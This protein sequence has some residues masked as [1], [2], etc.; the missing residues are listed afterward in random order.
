[1][2]VFP[3][4]T[5]NTE[6]IGEE[7][8]DAIIDNL[9][10]PRMLAFREVRVYDE[11]STPQPD[12]VSWR[13]TYGNWNSTFSFI[14][15]RNGSEVVTPAYIDYLSGMFQAGAINPGDNFRCTYCFDYFPA[16]VLKGYLDTVVNIVNTGAVGSATDYKI[17]TMPP[18]WDGVVADLV[19]ALCMER[20]ITDYTMWRGRLIF[21]I[22]G[23]Q[24][25]EGGGD[26]ISQLETIK[27]NAE[28]RA[29]KTI[30]NEKFK[31]G[32]LLSGP[33]QVYYNAVRGVGRGGTHSYGKTRGWR[34][35]SWI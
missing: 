29:Y 25:E 34:R 22:S 9:L 20:L 28:D 33:T 31:I 14:F 12:G 21:A 3:G 27:S 16:V 18:W 11:P 30:D 35:N 23:N 8:Y 2:P 4:T 6:A 17:T 15:A 24:L 10:T 13:Q 26:I 19:V 32:N 7:H 1:M 5:I